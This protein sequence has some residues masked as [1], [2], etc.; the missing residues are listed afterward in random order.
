MS[1]SVQ[2]IFDFGSDAQR[3]APVQDGY[4]LIGRH[5]ECQIRPKSRSVSR[6]HA[7]LLNSGGQ[8]RIRDLGSTS[9]TRINDEKLKPRKW[10]PLADNDRVRMGKVFFNIAIDG[11]V[12]ENM[13]VM[14][15]AEGFREDEI[16]EFLLAEDDVQ[17]QQRIDSIKT[18]NAAKQAAKLD[19]EAAEIGDEDFSDSGVGLNPNESDETLVHDTISG[20][21]SDSAERQRSPAP[22][23]S[24]NRRER[25]K[26]SAARRLS[27]GGPGMFSGPGN[28]WWKLAIAVVLAVSAIGIVA[29][30]FTGSSNPRDG[31]VIEGLN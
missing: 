24:G 2:L 16:S 25:K 11:S 27:S 19:L 30:S 1:V 10:Y 22:A 7:L 20:Q 15:A 26:P 12:Q 31:Q 8:L 18:Q 17:R 13:P 5:T 28:E 4:Y 6:H 29:W 9:G 23:A 14:E 21:R 3:A